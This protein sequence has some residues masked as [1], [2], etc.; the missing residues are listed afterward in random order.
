VKILSL[1][2]GVQSTALF[3]MSCHGELPKLDAAIFAD[4]KWEPKEVYTHLKRLKKEAK[5]YGIP[6]YEVSIGDIRQAHI[7]AKIRE[8]NVE[9]GRRMID[10]PVYT[11]Q[12]NKKGM[13]KR[14]CTSEYKI[15]P[16]QK[17]VRELLGYKK[18]QR[19]KAGSCE[20]WLGISTDEIKRAK[21]SQVKWI[22][23]HFPLILDKKMNRREIITW[24][25]NYYPE[26]VVPRSACIGC[27]FHSN[28]EWLNLTS[29][30][31]KD[32]I[33]FDKAIRGKG[34]DHVDS[35]L[36]L[37]RDCVPLDEVILTNIDQYDLFETECTGMCN[38]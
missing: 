29:E 27:P 9:N 17:K 25:E 5:K 6:I 13:I 24:L 1:G 3:L 19:I 37:H 18:G 32:A 10:I 2:A 7:Q 38:T 4:T 14:Q 12:G 26:W 34:G 15:K 35:Q 16:V 31:F 23:H 8:S 20:M 30:E 33:E 22:D 11:L 21:M 36:Y 28:Q